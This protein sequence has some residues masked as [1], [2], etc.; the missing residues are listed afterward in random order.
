MRFQELL[1]PPEQGTVRD[2]FK[3]RRRSGRDDQVRLHLILL[4]RNPATVDIPAL[5]PGKTVAPPQGE[6]QAFIN[7]L[8]LA[9][10]VSLPLWAGIIGVVRAVLLH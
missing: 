2:E 7:G 6:D 1:R 8:V 4:L 3:N 5:L 10:A 9:L